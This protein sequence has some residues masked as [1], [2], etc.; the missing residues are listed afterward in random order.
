MRREVTMLAMLEVCEGVQGE[1][2]VEQWMPSDTEIIED[3]EEQ[4]GEIMKVE[5]WAD[6]YG[7]PVVAMKTRL[8]ALVKAKKL[9]AR[10]ACGARVYGPVSTIVR[11][12]ARVRVALVRMAGDREFVTASCARIGAEARVSAQ[13]AWLAM[14]RLEEAGFVRRVRRGRSR[15]GSTWRVTR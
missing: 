4:L 13:D 10:K 12:T 6:W 5:W 7:V 11:V 9:A 15:A 1:P 14:R 3:A 2:V 8:E